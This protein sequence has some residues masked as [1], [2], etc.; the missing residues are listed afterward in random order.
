MTIK[1]FFKKHLRK[2]VKFPAS[3]RAYVLLKDLKGIEIGASSQ[4]DFRLNSLNVDVSSNENPDE[5]FYKE[6]KRHGNAVKKVDVV[7]S[8]DNVPFDDESLDYVI[9]S[10]VL[11]HFFDPIKALIE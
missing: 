7:A 6:Q 8:G 1:N 5:V 10:H 3:K 4:C 11:E 9:S 2:I